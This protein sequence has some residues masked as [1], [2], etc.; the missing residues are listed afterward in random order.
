MSTLTRGDNLS[1]LPSAIA[2]F[3]RP[4]GEAEVLIGV[5]DEVSSEQLAALEAKMASSGLPLRAQFGSTAEWDRALRLC[6][7]RPGRI[8]GV[9]FLPLLVRIPATLGAVGIAGILGWRI[10]EGISEITKKI[11]PLALIAAGAV[12]AI[13]YLR[14][15]A[16]R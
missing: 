8:R 14:G 13:A 2:E 15:P 9:A 1:P 5:E 3:V 11:I 4:G 6:F 12:V 16:S 7:R 10:G